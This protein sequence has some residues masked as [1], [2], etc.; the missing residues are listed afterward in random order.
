[1]KPR[2]SMITLGVKDLVQAVKFYRDGLG[3]PQMESP[4]SVAFFTLNGTWLGL[5]GHDDLA[6]DASISP[7]G[8]GFNGFA[9]AHNVA[10]EAEV[11]QV[12]GQALAAGATLAKPAQKTF[13]GGYSGYFKDLDGH[14]WE[15][16]HNP[17][18]WVGPEDAWGV[19]D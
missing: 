17:F 5:Y 19:M 6:E 18:F 14:L 1:M 9:L 2:I 12:I 15:V 8:S 3:F 7:A 4:P 13:W 16:A 10:T 11:D